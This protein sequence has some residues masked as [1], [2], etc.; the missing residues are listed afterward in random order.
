MLLNDNIREVKMTQGCG[1]QKKVSYHQSTEKKLILQKQEQKLTMMHTI[2][3][4]IIEKG[5]QS[6]FI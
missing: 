5:T 1:K 4:I 6:N 3:K 2:M